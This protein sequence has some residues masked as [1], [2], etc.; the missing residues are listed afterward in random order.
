MGLS[1]RLIA[2]DGLIWNT[3][4]QEVVLPTTTGQIGLLEGHAPLITA[5]EIGVLRIKVDQSWKPILSLGGFASIKNDEVTVLVSGIEE[6][7]KE[8][9]EEAQSLLQQATENLSLAQS[10]KE[11]IEASQNLKRAVA[12]FQAYQFIN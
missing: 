6:V 12:R 3:P 5:L 9:Y 4:I 8:N 11:K 10:L 2:P 1:I 7:V